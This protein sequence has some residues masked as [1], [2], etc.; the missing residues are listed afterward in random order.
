MMLRITGAAASSRVARVGR[1]ALRNSSAVCVQKN[2]TTTS[3][4]IHKQETYKE[5]LL[6]SHHPIRSFSSALAPTPSCDFSSDQEAIDEAN[7]RPDAKVEIKE[8][9]DGRGFGLYSRKDLKKGELVF[10]GAALSI[11]TTRTTHTVQ[12]DWDKHVTMDMPATL[13]NHSCEANVGIQENELGAYDFFALCD[14]PINTEVLW[15][16][17]TAEDEI[18]NFPCF[19][20]ADKCRGTLQGF[21]SHGDEVLKAYGSEY[22]A[23]YLLQKRT[24]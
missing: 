13:V 21:N 8:T 24:N 22:V 2:G 7:A 10:R 5:M 3:N 14:I 4:G 1:M 11:D 20:G 17:E 6:G 18:A 19:C 15:D 23:S 9:N 12:V 16:Y